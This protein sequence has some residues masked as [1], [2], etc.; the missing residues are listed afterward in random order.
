MTGFCSLEHPVPLSLPR[1]SCSPFRAQLK[2]LHC[3]KILE[4]ESVNPSCWALPQ[5]L[6]VS[7][8]SL[9]FTVYFFHSYLHLHLGCVH[10]ED[11]IPIPRHYLL[12]GQLCSKVA[13]IQLAAHVQR[14][15][16]GWAC[17]RL[18]RNNHSF[19]QCHT[20]WIQ[21]GNTAKASAL[22]FQVSNLVP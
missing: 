21:R 19:I 14:L 3:C 9:N 18:A 12:A 5:H 10:P 1:K 16:R 15:R 6:T 4:E 2:W 8:L 13:Q 7:S 20:S 11:N 22:G 17:S